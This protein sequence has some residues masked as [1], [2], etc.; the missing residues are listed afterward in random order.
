MISDAHSWCACENSPEG[1]PWVTIAKPKDTAL[2]VGRTNR[3]KVGQS[4]QAPLFSETVSMATAT[5]DIRSQHLS[6]SVSPRSLS[7]VHEVKVHGF[8]LLFFPVTN[9]DE[10]LSCALAYL[11]IFSKE[12]TIQICRPFL[13]VTI[14]LLVE[15]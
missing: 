10:H 12:M 1:L 8:Y 9:G 13:S 2:N 14:C 4:S 11:Y 6:S 3:E 5:M 7:C 15:L